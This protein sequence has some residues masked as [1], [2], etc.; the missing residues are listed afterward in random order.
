[1]VLAGR[2]S[3]PGTIVAPGPVGTTPRRSRSVEGV[4]AGAGTL[5]VRVVDRE[6]LL[7]D[8]VHEVDGRTGQVGSAHLV[9]HDMHGTES[10][11]DVPVHL[12]LVEVELVAQSRAPARLHCDAQPQVVAALLLQQGTY[13]RR[14]GV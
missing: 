3:R 1:M 4:A 9:G 8:G 6:A 14:R 5:R 7:L 12:T 11:V 10:R 13:L 2:A